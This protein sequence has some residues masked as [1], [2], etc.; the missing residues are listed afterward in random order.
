MKKLLIRI[1]AL[2][3]FAAVCS[4]ESFTI[5]IQVPA[6]GSVSWTNDLSLGRMVRF[7]GGVNTYTNIAARTNVIVG[8]VDLDIGTNTYPAVYF[9]TTATGTVAVSTS[10]LIN[11]TLW[12]T[13][14]AIL[15][16]T[17]SYTVEVSGLLLSAETNK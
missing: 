12:M 8:K 4:A 1:A 16:V 2:L 6:G 15:T 14:G 5:Q 11:S 3:V 13:N 9:A 17:N 10:F 7:T